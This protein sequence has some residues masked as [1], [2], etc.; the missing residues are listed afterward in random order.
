MRRVTVHAIL[1]DRRMVPEKRTPFFGMAG[2]T[3]IID[4]MIQ[5]HLPPLAAMR[6]VAGS[7]ADLHVAK[8]GAKQVGGALEQ[9]LSLINMAAET[10]F[11]NRW[12]RQQVFGQ[13]RVK[14]LR[15]LGVGLFGE[16]QGHSLD[17]FRMVDAVTRHAAHIASVVFPAPP[18]KAAA[19]A[20]MAKQTRFIDLRWRWIGRRVRVCAFLAPATGFGVLFAISVADFARSA[21]RVSQKLGAL[22][23]SVES[24]RLHH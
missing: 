4:G 12:C 16:V 15:D 23:M 2:V 1:A 20:G 14:N 22:A 9:S 8:L 10:S 24:E 6:I 17:Q 13:S 19:V 21:A 11:F 18:L 5:E 7:A 3:H